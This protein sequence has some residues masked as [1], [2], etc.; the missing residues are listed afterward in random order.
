M[1]AVPRHARGTRRVCAGGVSREGVERGSAAGAARSQTALRT[2][3]ASRRVRMRLREDRKLNIADT[4][5]LMLEQESIPG[6]S[7]NTDP[8]ATVFPD[9]DLA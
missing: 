2:A 8:S 7:A 6:V 9:Q 1:T 3:S 5:P 4:P